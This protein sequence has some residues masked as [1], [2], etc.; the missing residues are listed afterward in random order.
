MPQTLADVSNFL[1]EKV[2]IKIGERSVA[3][4]LVGAS[5]TNIRSLRDPVRRELSG[6]KYIKGFD[7]Y[8][9]EELFEELL[10]GKR[11]SDLLELENMLAKS[12][13]AVVILLEGPGSIAE[14]GAFANHKEL[15]DKLVVVVDRKHHRDKSFIL[16]GPLKYLEKK[17]GSV[18]IYHDFRNPDLETLGEHIRKAVNKIAKEVTVDRTVAN[19]VA[20]QH[21]LLAA[22]YALEPVNLAALEE[23]IREACRGNEIVSY[24]ITNTSLNILLRQ[25]E[26]TLRDGRYHLTDTGLKRLRMLMKLEKEGKAIQHSL[27]SIRIQIMNETLRKPITLQL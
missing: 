22:I 19:P 4:F 15:C 16:L 26:I 27:D 5:R 24:T 17:T 12:V 13:H 11:K 25:G 18:V 20:A 9:P 10:S 7:V 3:I 2:F 21:F 8:Y 1:N 6:K 23:V 14:L